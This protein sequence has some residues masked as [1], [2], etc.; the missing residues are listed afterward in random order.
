MNFDINRF[1][2][3]EHQDFGDSQ[4]FE[5]KRPFTCP[6]GNTSFNL[7]GRRIKSAHRAGAS[8]EWVV[9]SIA[10]MTD[11]LISKLSQYRKRPEPVR[12]SRESI[13]PVA[14]G[15]YGRGN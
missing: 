13:A 7:Y 12:R 11:T 9:K 8:G 2:P 10:V 14:T 4:A 1:F 6:P 15:G 3:D 5:E